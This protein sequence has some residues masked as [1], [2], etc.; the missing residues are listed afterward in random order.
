[1]AGGESDVNVLL[2]GMT[3]DFNL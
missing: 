1:M 3:C 2:T